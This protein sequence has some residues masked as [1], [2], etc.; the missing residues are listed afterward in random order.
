MKAYQVIMRTSDGQ[1]IWIQ[2]P[3]LWP[4]AQEV[5]GRR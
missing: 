3:I 1:L 2:R 4:A 5:S